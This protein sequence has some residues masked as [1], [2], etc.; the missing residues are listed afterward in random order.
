MSKN[1][2]L[3]TGKAGQKAVDMYKAVEA[4]FCTKFL[5]KDETVDQGYTLKT[6]ATAEKVIK[7]Y[8]RIEDCVVSG[9]KKIEDKFVAAFLE[10][11][12]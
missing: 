2:R 7:V 8:Q 10:E 5:E 4:R 3:K 1:Y 9:Y 12:D 6:G 11:V